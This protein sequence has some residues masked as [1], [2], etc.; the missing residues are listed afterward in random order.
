[1]SDPIDLVLNPGGTVTRHFTY[2][3]P[4][5]TYGLS[6]QFEAK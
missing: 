1:V 2:L 3:L 4:T 5:G 6:S